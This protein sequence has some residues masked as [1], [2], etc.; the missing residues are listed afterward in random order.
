[1]PS[2]LILK[3]LEIQ[4]FRGIRE[5]KIGRLGRVNLIVG[6]NNV[7]KSTVLEALQLYAKPGSLPELLHILVSR[8]ELPTASLNYWKK[9]NGFDFPIESIF[10]QPREIDVLTKP[11]PMGPPKAIEIGPEG[12]VDQRYQ[13]SLRSE[14]D[15]RPFRVGHPMPSKLWFL[16]L[17]FQDS[18]LAFR[19]ANDPADSVSELF[20]NLNNT[21][22][23]TQS[24]SFPSINSSY[25]QPTGLSE[26][27]IGRLW[28]KISL[29]EYESDVIAAM[30]IILPEVERIA[31]RESDHTESHLLDSRQKSSVKKRAPYAKL[32]GTS[33][34]R[35]LKALGDGVNRLFGLALSLV[36]SKDGFLLIDEIENGVHY[37]VQA[38]LWRLI[39]KTASRLNVQ[40]F[41]TTHSYDCIKAFE[42]AA[43]DS[44]EE[45]VMIRLVKRNDEIV[46]VEFEKDELSIAVDGQIE[47]R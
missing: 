45:G 47:I 27:L 40:V 4:R 5:L 41:A 7:G 25:V 38:D 13:I 16:R 43:R 28:D 36:N 33:S 34:P 9:E 3:S 10:N 6:K 20:F 26:G 44:V 23:N 2:D 14:V 39:F 31:L 37:S 29:T 32:F 42:E 17:E 15:P 24:E 21:V 18:L 19:M 22:R 8:G 35:P 11:I 30:R 46:V 12:S 1:M